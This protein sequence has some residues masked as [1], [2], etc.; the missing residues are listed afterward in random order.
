MNNVRNKIDGSG[1]TGQAEPRV[2]LMAATFNGFSN[3]NPEFS[4]I[5]AG[6]SRSTTNNDLQRKVTRNEIDDRGTRVNIPSDVRTAQRQ[7]GTG[8]QARTGNENLRFH[9]PLGPSF[10]NGNNSSRWYQE[11]GN[12]QIFRTFPGDE[13]FVGDRRG[14]PRSEAFAD[15]NLSTK[16]G[17]G[18]GMTFNGR[19][20]VLEHN[21]SRDVMLFQSKGTGENTSEASL[22]RGALEEPAWGV[23]M[24]AEKDGDIVLRERRASTERRRDGTLRPV[25]NVIDTN[26]DI[27]ESFNLRVKDDGRNYEAFID[28][29]SMA[30]GTW[31]RGNT[32]TVARWG[33]YVQAEPFESQAGRGGKL[34]GDQEQVV[35]V[36]GAKVTV[37]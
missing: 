33:N 6:E 35:L 17:D 32:P 23:A 28:D 7:T 15:S 20:H 16:F 24:F 22:K 36:S 37:E 21:G 30:S 13:N 12:T 25:D 4:E 9:N 8:S 18:K 3:S 26:K 19:F 14:A 10:T 1:H 29:K 34:T 5:V 31:D 27:G 2:M 11:T